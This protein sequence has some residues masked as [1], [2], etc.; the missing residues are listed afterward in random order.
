MDMIADKPCPIHVLDF[1]AFQG[2]RGFRLKQPHR[3]C[4][5]ELLLFTQGSGLHH[6]DDRTLPYAPCTLFPVASGQVQS[7]AGFEDTRGYAILFTEQYLYHH[8]CDLDWLLGTHL[9]A[10]DTHPRVLNLPLPTYRGLVWLARRIRTELEK[11]SDFAQDAI[12]RNLLKLFILE[13]ERV[14][15]EQGTSIQPPPGENQLFTQFKLSLEENYRQSR[16]VQE[17]AQ[18][19]CVTPKKLNQ[20]AR[21]YA[22]KTAKQFIDERVVLEIKRLLTHTDWSIQEIAR[23]LAFDEA[24]NMAKFFKRYTHSTPAKFRNTCTP[25]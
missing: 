3:L 8:D 6:V 14:K 1:K 4:F 5:H 22:R 9:F 20:I 15:Q 25:S 18:T 11:G 23:H 7:F 10:L 24:T 12:L 17:Y 2:I 19:L 21:R 13:A 16:C